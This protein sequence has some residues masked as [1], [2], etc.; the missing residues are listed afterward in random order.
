MDARLRRVLDH[1]HANFSHQLLVNELAEIACLTPSALHRLFRRHTR[2]T[3]IEYVTRLRIG[4][5]CS[6][7]MDKE[8]S[9]AGVADAVGYANLADRK[10]VV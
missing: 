6:I 7:L 9:I 8:L 5:A 1:L 10:S 2:M 3:P 4:R